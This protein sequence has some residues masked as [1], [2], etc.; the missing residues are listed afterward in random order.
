MNRCARVRPRPSTPTRASR[1]QKRF[2][3]WHSSTLAEQSSVGGLS[4]AADDTPITFI[5]VYHHRGGDQRNGGKDI[6]VYQL[7]LRRT[8]VRGGPSSGYA[9]YTWRSTLLDRHVDAP[10]CHNAHRGATACARRWRA[11]RHN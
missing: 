7:P 3:L 2:E 6:H 4:L 11:L 5:A 1:C 9:A 8:V 10:V